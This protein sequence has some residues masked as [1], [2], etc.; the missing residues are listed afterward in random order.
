MTTVL[1][2]DDVQENRY[3]LET[4]LKGNGYD[5]LLA[6]QGRQALDI[7]RSQP[8]D[9][10]IS[11][12]LM[13]V[14]DGFTLCK[15]CKL[16]EALAKVPFIFYT[17]TYTDAKDE[18]FALSLGADLFLIKPLQPEELL[19]QVA[20]FV[21]DDATAKRPNL[22]GEEMEFFRQ[23]N[24]ALFGKLEEKMLELEKEIAERKRA[25]ALTHELN[26]T[27][28]ERIKE[29][30]AELEDT[31]RELEAFAYSVS[32]DLRAPLQLVVGFGDLLS[33]HYS[34]QLDAKGQHFLEVICSEAQHMGQLINDLLTFSRMGKNAMQPERLDMDVL[35]KTEFNACSQWEPGRLID[36]RVQPTPST[37]ADHV[38][39]RQVVIN[40]LSNAIKY[41]RPQEHAVIEV[42]GKAEGTE[43]VYWV[44]DNGVGFDMQNAQM[45]FDVF[46]RMHSQAQFE[47][48][49]LGLAIVRRIIQ[50]HGGK[51]WADSAINA[52]TTIFFT[53]P[54][55]RE[56][57]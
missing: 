45:L 11:D 5:V 34:S 53:I 24:A 3:L 48:T 22:L 17:A 56:M 13:P 10:I 26:L 7:L 15:E 37:I 16:D 40:L 18:K 23:H 55:A 33:T 20:K 9:L 1:I 29:R 41:T 31:N 30:T 43:N 2:A 6:E 21:T 25:E 27:L 46:Q 35:F 50:R 32:H 44:K 38:S 4:L 52:G 47:G 51:V 28:E 8:V 54:C 49:G 36:F 42:G 12:I 39:I 57:S 19:K 14:M